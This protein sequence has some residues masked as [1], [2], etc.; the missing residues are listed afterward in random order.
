T[1]LRDY[2]VEIA[3]RAGVPDPVIGT[4]RVGMHLL[5]RG[6]PSTDGVTLALF[7]HHGELQGEV[8]KR[9]FPISTCIVSERGPV[10]EELARDLHGPDILFRSLARNTYVRDGQALVASLAL[11]GARTRT[12][13]VL[14]LRLAGERPA[15]LQTLRVDT[16]GADGTR[17]REL[18]IVDAGLLVPPA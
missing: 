6:S 4:A 16:A 7:L 18:T 15:P 17:T 13:E 14:V 2:D 8:R 11:Q 12:Q 10:Y 9:E 1:F 5:L 3:Q